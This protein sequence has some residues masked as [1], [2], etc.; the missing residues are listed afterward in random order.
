[1]EKNANR[2]VPSKALLEILNDMTLVEKIAYAGC[3]N[4]GDE[5][6]TE[7]DARFGAVDNYRLTLI[8][9]ISNSVICATQDGG[10]KDGGT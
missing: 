1:M 10:G 2:A 6:C 7:C 9:M 5:C 8:R 3:C 4:E